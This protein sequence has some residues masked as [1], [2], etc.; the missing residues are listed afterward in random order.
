MITITIMMT[1]RWYIFSSIVP[2]V[3]SRYTV[4]ALLTHGVWKGA[5]L[6]VWRIL[7]CNPLFEGG[8]DPVPGLAGATLSGEPQACACSGGRSHDE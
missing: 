2:D 1:W 7:R 8:L 5:A 4:T 3:S 6:A